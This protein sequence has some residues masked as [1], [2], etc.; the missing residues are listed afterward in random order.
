MNTITID[1]GIYRRAELYAKLHNIS[2]RDA[3]ER[4]LTMLVSTKFSKE[5]KKVS[6]LDKAMDLMDS[7]MIK[8]GKVV[9]SD[10]N[11]IEALIE[12]KYK[13]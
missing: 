1:S 13:L 10:A 12:T 11:G 3:I 9:P 2:V 8:G 7:M 4:G 5:N 6:Q